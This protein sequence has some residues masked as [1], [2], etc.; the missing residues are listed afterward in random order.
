MIGNN[1]ATGVF[2][3]LENN[4]VLPAKGENTTLLWH[5]NS[6]PMYVSYRTWICTMRDK[7]TFIESLL[8]PILET[9]HMFINIKM[10]K[11]QYIHAME[12]YTAKTI[13]KLQLDALLWMN[14]TNITLSKGSQTQ[15]NSHGLT[16]YKSV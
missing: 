10:D 11:L 5:A 9:I 14:A 3:H 2:K 6:I 7:D 8:L 13:N 4:L 15:N 16:W 12:C 1:T